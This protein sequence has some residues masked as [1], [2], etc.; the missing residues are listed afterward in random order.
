MVEEKGLFRYPEP[1]NSLGG[2]PMQ[3]YDRDGTPIAQQQA[4]SS[5]SS[6]VY[7]WMAL[8]LA[9][10]AMIAYF[11]YATGAFIRL[12][13]MWWLLAF[14]TF[15]IA[16]A[17]NASINRI[18][19]G[20]AAALFLAYAG[21][22]GL[23]FGTILPAYAAAFGGSVIWSAFATGAM[24][25]AIAA[26]YGIFTKSDLTSLGRILRVGL[27]GLIAASFLFM[28]LSFFMQLTLFHLLISY[29]GLGLFVGLTAY[30]ANTIRKM[31]LQVDPNS[32]ASYKLSLIMALKMYIN[33]IMIF[34]YLLQIF[35]SSSRR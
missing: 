18:S 35:S 25:F 12:M 4:I 14:G 24:I 16:M 13:P 7:G 6:R 32:V 3:L 10:T 2:F 20:G 23:F 1:F 27:M 11:T 34:W 29:V 8:G 19:F 33:V 26:G 22:Q 17:F 30:D 15:G 9:L 28:I 5:F 21:V 31:S